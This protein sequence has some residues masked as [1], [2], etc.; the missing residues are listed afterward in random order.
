MAARAIGAG[1]RA[2]LRH[3]MGGEIEAE[4][5]ALLRH[6]LLARPRLALGQPQIGLRM[7]LA[8][9]QRGLPARLFAHRG[10]G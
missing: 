5:L 9:E 10:I 8:A 1:D 3:R 6:L 2:P 7:I 4:I